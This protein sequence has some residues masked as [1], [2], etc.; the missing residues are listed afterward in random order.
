MKQLLI[1]KTF[2]VVFLVFTFG[3]AQ[4]QTKTFTEK[5]N[6]AENAIIN[7][8]TTHTDIEFITWDKNEVA[9]EVIIEIEGVEAKQ[10]EAYFKQN[11]IKI[12]GNSKQIDITTGV[13]NTWFFKHAIGGFNALPNSQDLKFAEIAKIAKLENLSFMMDS[14]K[15]PDFPKNQVFTFDYE[16]FK[17][18]G[19]AYLKKW[20]KNYETNTSSADQE[21]FKKMVIE[22]ET[23]LKTGRKLK[24]D[25]INTGASA[26]EKRRNELNHRREELREQRI[27]AY[28]QRRNKLVQARAENLGENNRQHNDQEKNVDKQLAV[29]IRAM[30][31]REKQISVMNVDSLF[32]STR[33]LQNGS[34]HIY[35]VASDKQ[36]NSAKVKIKKHLKISMP[37]SVTLKMNVRHGEVKLAENTKNINGTFAYSG[38]YAMTIDGDKT[39][40]DAS[41]S[42]INIQNWNYGKLKV[43]YSDQ[44]AIKQVGNLTLSAVSSEVTIDKLIKKIFSEN[45]FGALTIK[46]VSDTFTSIE[47][48]MKNGELLCKIPKIPFTFSVNGENSDVVYP[49]TLK[50]DK[51]TIVNS[52]LYKG[53][54]MSKNPD[55]TISINAKFSDI[56]L[57]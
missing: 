8:N 39:Q 24:Q 53:F 17:K 51:T 26:Y 1:Y 6:V 27:E 11:D 40:I 15:F 37:K 2:T 20:K 57:E 52:T 32:L 38:L 42:P 45:S 46:N 48:A 13:E 19:D 44:V 31:K 36:G 43:N 30:E 16:A 50:I 47:I 55:K 22:Y 10:M 12:L 4:K 9:I 49:A 29:L 14:L 34:P 33:S 18:D 54:Y 3:N 7:I 25:T 35:Y 41:Y 56:V 5:Y 28:E 23:L 21:K